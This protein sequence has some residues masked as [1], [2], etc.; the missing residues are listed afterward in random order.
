MVVN[1]LTKRQLNP[2][3]AI[4]L[5]PRGLRKGSHPATMP[6]LVDAGLV[7]QRSRTHGRWGEMARFV[8][9]AGRNALANAEPLEVRTPD[10]D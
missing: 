3:L 7:E 10:Q 6:G 5:N 2:L 4:K 8:T 9:D 1:D